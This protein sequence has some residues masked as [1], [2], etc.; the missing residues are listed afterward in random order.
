MQ[1]YSLPERSTPRSTTVAPAPSA[2]RLPDTCSPAGAPTAAARPSGSHTTAATMST[3]ALMIERA[4]VGCRSDMAVL[5][6][7]GLMTW[8]P[9]PETAAPLLTRR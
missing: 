4:T 3:T 1:A 9:D 7:Q 5:L 2:N 8:L 6:R